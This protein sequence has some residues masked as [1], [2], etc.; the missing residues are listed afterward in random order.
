[1]EKQWKKNS[2]SAAF[3]FFFG[4]W[5]NQI[6]VDG[7]PAYDCKDTESAH[8]SYSLLKLPD[9]SKPSKPAKT[10]KQTIQLLQPRE[11]H[12]VEF[13]SCQVEYRQKVFVCGSFSHIY[14]K[15]DHMESGI[16]SISRETCQNI[17]RYK[18]FHTANE[19]IISDLQGNSTITAEVLIAGSIETD[20]TCEN[21]NLITKK[22]TLEGLIYHEYEITLT[23][24]VATT[25]KHTGL[26][27]FS[28]TDS[29]R[30][31]EDQCALQ[32]LGNMYVDPFS[33]KNCDENKYKAIFEGEA[34]I[35]FNNDDTYKSVLVETTDVA[36]DLLVQGTERVCGRLLYRTEHPS[37]YLDLSESSL[38]VRDVEHVDKM[39]LHLMTYVNSKILY[40]AKK[41]EDNFKNLHELLAKKRC[42]LEAET[43]KNRAALA[44][45]DPDQFALAMN[46]LKPGMSG[47]LS[48]E[49]VHLFKCEKKSVTRRNTSECFDEIPV[50]YEGKDYFVSPRNRILTP[51]GSPRSCADPFPSCFHAGNGHWFYL[52]P[53]PKHCPTPNQIELHINATTW[54]YQ[55]IHSLQKAGVY[56][57]A[58]VVKY[59]RGL[60]MPSESHAEKNAMNSRY[61]GH[62]AYSG[63]GSGKN[64]MS[65]LDFHSMG[66]EM[67][68]T[69]KGFLHTV[70]DT[71][72]TII[73][74]LFMIFLVTQMLS[75]SLQNFALLKFHG[76]TL[77]GCLSVLPGAGL[78]LLFYK[79]FTGETEM[80]RFL[81]LTPEELVRLDKLITDAHAHFGLQRNLPHD[82]Q[83][84]SA[85]AIAPTSNSLER[86]GND[87]IACGNQNSPV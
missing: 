45:S 55:P 30:L 13:I 10:R 34:S 41:I 43:I 52:D 57:A 53:Y 16:M 86:N 26:T 7:L 62:S 19:H 11:T 4:V 32:D 68:G 70:G 21:G 74:I 17:H 5:L 12:H 33:P 67:W 48:G 47:K 24:G 72:A 82:E 14:L 64:L 54:K 87:V 36:F 79:K 8:A 3:L 6:V 25:D 38:F 1:M 49:V 18:T 77:S 83:P 71:T 29:C 42:Q 58:D 63:G 37:L 39:E 75:C 9:C 15:P 44:T 84:S 35:F 40:V 78:L 27:T 31:Y 60:V 50:I 69:V 56:T 2:V 65:E 23:N 51:V 28:S 81:R 22:G 73:A 59:Q 20:G 76:C 80:E 66:E 46:D 61:Y 85:P